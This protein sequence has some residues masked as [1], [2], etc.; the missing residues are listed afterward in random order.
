MISPVI[1]SS[2]HSTRRET[3][4]ALATKIASKQLLTRPE[5]AEALSLSV[6]MIDELVK[7]GDLP[8][9]K[10]GRSVRFRPSALEYFIEARETRVSRKRKG[11]ARK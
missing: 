2:P 6:R 5:A 1:D 7:T 11:G 8:H 10:I 9:V 4:E 3:A